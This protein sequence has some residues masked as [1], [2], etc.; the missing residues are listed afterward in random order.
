MFLWYEAIP[1]S[2]SHLLPPESQFEY[3]CLVDSLKP[4][5]KVAGMAI[6]N[7]LPL[8][9]LHAQ[10][11]SRLQL[12]TDIGLH[13]RDM[14]LERDALLSRTRT[15]DANDKAVYESQLHNWEVLTARWG[16]QDAPR[17]SRRT[18]S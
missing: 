12:L 1:V 15:F 13:I 16:S 7:Q 18:F 2:N 17:P 11:T 9:S 4:F 3:S 5:V 10:V 6:M 14:E 8:A